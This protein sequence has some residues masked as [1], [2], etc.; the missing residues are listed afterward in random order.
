MNYPQNWYTIIKK[1]FILVFLYLIK[2]VFILIFAFLLYYIWINFKE[3]LWIEVINYI[4]FP[5]ILIL[6]NYSFIR[7]ILWLIEYYN[8]L[9][10]IIWDQIFIVNSSLILVNDI[11]MIEAFKIVKLDS[12]SRWFFANLLSFWDIIIETSTREERIF[13]FMPTPFKI[14]DILKAQRKVVL[15]DRKKRYVVEDTPENKNEQLDKIQ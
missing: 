15:E 1:H 8:Y 3:S 13:R 2:F 7:L 10:I 6:V 9:F 4:F 5:L 12:F 11:E 14:L